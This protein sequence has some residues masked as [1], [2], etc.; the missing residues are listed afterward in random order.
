MLPGADPLWSPP[1]RQK[2]LCRRGLP[3][4]GP[5]LRCRRPRH[6]RTASPGRQRSAAPAPAAGC[7]PALCPRRHQRQCPGEAALLLPRRCRFAAQLHWRPHCDV[8]VPRRPVPPAQRGP[9]FGWQGKATPAHCWALPPQQRCPQGLV[10]ATAARAARRFAPPR[11]ALQCRARAAEAA[12]LL[13]L[14]PPRPCWPRSPLSA[15]LLDLAS[16]RPSVAAQRWRSQ[17]A[18][19]AP[20]AVAVL[21][22]RRG[23]VAVAAAATAAA[24]ALAA[25]GARPAGPPVPSPWRLLWRRRP[26]LPVAAAWE[27][28][29][30][31]RSF[32][33]CGACEALALP[34]D[35]KSGTPRA[36]SARSPRCP[37][38]RAAAPAP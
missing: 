30:P 35:L 37:C 4:P 38:P 28:I 10:M 12:L 31:R 27:R 8:V 24:A 3:P 20:P 33:S 17:D 11:R 7:Q 18:A 1:P 14:P 15:T 23:A 9:W 6:R 19:L 29:C 26:P 25:M 13:Q 36:R 2:R 22:L 32:Q 21:L 16:Q 34:S 5:L